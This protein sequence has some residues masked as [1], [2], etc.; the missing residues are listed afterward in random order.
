MLFIRGDRSATALSS[1]VTSTVLRT[2]GILN[3]GSH[4]INVLSGKIV[5]VNN[6]FASALDLRKVSSSYNVYYYVWDPNRGGTYGF[7][8]FQTFAWNGTDYDVVPGSGSYKPT[9]NVIENGQAFF[10]STNGADTTIQLT[11]NAK[12]N[13]ALSIVPFIPVTGGQK[14][15]SNLYLLNTD[16]SVFLADGVLQTF[17]D[18]YNDGIDGMDAT[19]IFNETEN[20]SILSNNKLMAVERRK[21]LSDRDSILFYLSGVKANAYRLEF[22]FSDINKAG[23]E[24]YLEDSYLKKRTPLNLND[25]N[26]YNFFVNNEAA[27]SSPG[28]F[29]IVFEA[30]TGA[31]PLTF[32]NVKAY[33]L[34][35]NISVEWYVENETGIRRYEIERSEDV[36][37]FTTIGTLEANNRLSG[38]YSFID[39]TPSQ[40]NIYYRIKSVD[41]DSKL[42]YSKVVKVF[43]SPGK[44]FIKLYPNPVRDGV[45]HLEIANNK[46]GAY[47]FRL[48]TG[49]GQ[50][51][52]LNEI[53]YEGGSAVKNIDIKTNVA[54]GIYSLEITMPDK[55][56]I[57]KK[58]I[59]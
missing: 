4:G 2:S 22:I 51:I 16:G 31:L 10:I 20:F 55:S 1:P 6:P 24:G 37:N 18:N 28:R 54:Q 44:D 58:V 38:N 52:F 8:A 29:K 46:Y 26:T 30:A 13:A 3:T 41:L 48:L 33:T 49:T 17:A 59:Y 50:L 47:Q 40:G 35:S 12:T 36:A 42:S 23:L 56:K 45:I 7:G 9:T 25:T 19:K 32:T 34:N 11:E 57:I 5:P 27:S 15:R 39:I 43:L 53:V 21:T 14:L